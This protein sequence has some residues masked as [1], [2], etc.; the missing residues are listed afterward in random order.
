MPRAP[1]RRWRLLQL[2]RRRSHQGRMP[3]ASS[4]RWRLLQ[5]WRRRS[6]QGRMYQASCLQ[7][8]L[9]YLQPRGA[10]RGGVSGETGR[11]LQ[12][13]QERRYGIMTRWR[14]FFAEWEK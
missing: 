6:H 12:E 4:G 11:C 8:H 14:F 1:S 9:S 2:W 5:L 13:L 7:G 3:P 10:S